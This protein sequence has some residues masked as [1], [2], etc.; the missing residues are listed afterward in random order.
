M[1]MIETL[2]TVSLFER[3]AIGPAGRLARLTV[4]LAL[5]LLEIFW[6]TPHWRDLWLG[7]GVLPL[8]ATGMAFA[9]SRLAE[10]PLRATGPLGHAAN[11]AIFLPLS[12]VP[13]M[14]GAAF[15]FYGVSMLLAAALRS[16]GC[17]VTVI[18]N[19][20]LRRD[21]QVGCALFGPVD[22]IEARARS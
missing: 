4:G 10:R 18:S 17:E 12:F 9:W 15:V 16:G 13:P 14:A 21:D 5:I 6:R 22:A 2:R 3:G 8:I 11:A 1:E 20:V 7:L 19:A